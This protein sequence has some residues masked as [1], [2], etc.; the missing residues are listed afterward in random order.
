LRGFPRWS[1]P[2]F[3][4]LVFFLLFFEALRFSDEGGFLGS[5]GIFFSLRRSSG[6]LLA[7]FRTLSALPDMLSFIRFHL[8]ETIFNTSSTGRLNSPLPLSLVFVFLCPPTLRTPGLSPSRGRPTRSCFGSPLRRGRAR[9]DPPF[10]GGRFLTPFGVSL[11]S[12]F[13]F[14]LLFRDTPRVLFTPFF[15]YV[16][17]S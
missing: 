7:V 1:G 16:L 11:L 10:F 17:S 14:F 8:V 5:G 4:L 13:F 12:S 6:C 15:P 2:V 3:S 9:G